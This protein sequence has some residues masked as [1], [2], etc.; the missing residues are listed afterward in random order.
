MNKLNIQAPFDDDTVERLHAG[1]VVADIGIWMKST[2][3]AL[4]AANALGGAGVCIGRA[5]GEAIN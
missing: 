1:D 4:I 2:G 5:S 3:E